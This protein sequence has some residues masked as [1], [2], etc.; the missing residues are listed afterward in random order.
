MSERNDQF[1]ELLVQYHPWLYVLP[2]NQ[3]AVQF[4]YVELGYPRYENH[5]IVAT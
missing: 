4:K 2:Q 3:G 5:L 1:S